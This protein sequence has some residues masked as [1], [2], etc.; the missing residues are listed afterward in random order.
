M[1]GEVE[2]KCDRSLF[3]PPASFDFLLRRFHYLDL[4]DGN[5]E[6]LRRLQLARKSPPGPTR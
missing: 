4:R 5:R 3:K 1:P 2:S 6:P